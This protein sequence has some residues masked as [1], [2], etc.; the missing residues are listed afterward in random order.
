[1]RKTA[2]AALLPLGSGLSV[3]AELLRHRPMARL[4]QN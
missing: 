3:H 4:L 2:L 1:M